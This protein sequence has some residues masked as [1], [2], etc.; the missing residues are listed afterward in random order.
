MSEDPNTQAARV[1]RKATTHDGEP[2]P[3]DV[4]KAWEAWIAQIKQVDERARTLLRAAFEAGVEAGG[5][6]FAASGGRA[7]GKARADRLSPERRS[8]IARDAAKARWSDQSS[9]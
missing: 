8:E 3:A 9:T 5:K 1:V 7:G 6:A 4:E 2:L